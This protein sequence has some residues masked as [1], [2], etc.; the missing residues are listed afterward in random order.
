MTDYIYSR[1]NKQRLR[2][3]GLTFL[4][5]LSYTKSP[6]EDVREVSGTFNGLCTVKRTFLF[7]PQTRLMWLLP[8]NHLHLINSQ[9]HNK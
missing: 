4:K 3:V 7:S 6:E 2:L 5:G 9:L 1:V 8:S